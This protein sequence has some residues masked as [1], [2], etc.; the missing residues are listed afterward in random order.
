MLAGVELESRIRALETARGAK[1]I[2]G[3]SRRVDDGEG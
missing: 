3:E 1:L 2:T